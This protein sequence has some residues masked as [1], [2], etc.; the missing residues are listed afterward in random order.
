[1]GEGKTAINPSEISLFV[2]F[3]ITYVIEKIQVRFPMQ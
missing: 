2:N 1:M 3:I